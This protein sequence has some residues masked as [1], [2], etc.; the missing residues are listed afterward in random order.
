[1][2]TV[3]LFG[4]TRLKAGVKELRVDARCVRDVYSPLFEKIQAV[5]PDTP[6]TA[7]DIKNCLVSVNGNTAGSLT[8]L[9]DGD[10]VF[11]FTASAGG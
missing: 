8:R 10:T 6:L 1:M 7:K 2:V 11:L 5:N 3:K 4:T 9:K